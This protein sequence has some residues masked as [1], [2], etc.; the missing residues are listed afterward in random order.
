MGVSVEEQAEQTTSGRIQRA[1]EKKPVANFPATIAVVR[2]QDRN[3]ALDG[4]SGLRAR[5]YGGFS[6]VPVRN[7]EQDADPFAA[8]GEL[9]GIRAVA[10]LNRLVIPGDARDIDDLRLAA[11]NVQA[12]MLLAYTFD[13]QF[14]SDE[15]ALPLAVITLGLSPTRKAR[16]ESTV[17]ALL[18]DTRS[19]F[20][21]GLAEGSAK[22]T[23]AANGWTNRSAIEQ[24]RRRVEAE[25]FEQMVNELAPMWKSVNSTYGQ[26]GATPGP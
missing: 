18:V 8:L 7:E 21:Y 2:I 12:D 15:N 11:A 4:N 10:P 26:P 14:R 25:A 1:F 9:N 20:I 13:T 6:T 16:V 5:N 22:D 3:Y 19:G 23:Q 24:T 17:S